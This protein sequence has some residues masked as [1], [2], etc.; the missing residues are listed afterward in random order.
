MPQVASRPWDLPGPPRIPR[1]RFR[2]H[3]GEEPRVPPARPLQIR[4][5]A[6]S[7]P[8][9]AK[10]PPQLGNG[11]PS[12]FR[13]LWPALSPCWPGPSTYVTA[14][15]NAPPTRGRSAK[16]GKVSGVKA[17]GQPAAMLVEGS[18]GFLRSRGRTGAGNRGRRR[19]RAARTR[20][21]CEPARPGAGAGARAGVG[22]P[23]G[24]KA[25]A[26]KGGRRT[27]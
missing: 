1:R 5:P 25:G 20:G 22:V 6:R 23:Q 7:P 27:H 15:G 26:G 10:K 12:Y 9:R 11:A 17:G 21:V 18:S 2:A 16:I 4:A 24:A 14:E 13:H 3:S 8:P 19:S